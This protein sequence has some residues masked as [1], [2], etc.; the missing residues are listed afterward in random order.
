[1]VVMINYFIVTDVSFVKSFALTTFVLLLNKLANVFFSLSI[2]N[3]IHNAV[4]FADVCAEHGSKMFVVVVAGM[5][6]PLLRPPFSSQ[7][8]LPT[9]TEAPKIFVDVV[10][11]MTGPQFLTTSS[12]TAPLQTTAIMFSEMEV[13]A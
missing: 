11:V 8:P 10:A 1:M 3:T 9:S 7:A 2:S 4:R 5:G 6:A 12:S 13:L